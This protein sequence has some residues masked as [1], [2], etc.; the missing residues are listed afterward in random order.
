MTGIR[1]LIVDDEPLARAQMAGI[2]IGNGWC[3][4]VDTFGRHQGCDV[5][6]WQESRCGL[7]VDQQGVREVLR[8]ADMALRVHIVLL[9]GAEVV[10]FCSTV[11]DSSA[12]GDR[13]FHVSGRSDDARV[14]LTGA[15]VAFLGR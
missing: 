6:F 1:I 15:P 14:R 10:V 9:L 3:L 13:L 2:A 12:V 4:G 5:V 11:N 8:T 7:A